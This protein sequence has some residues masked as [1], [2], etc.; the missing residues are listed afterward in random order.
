MCGLFGF[1]SYTSTPP[2]KLDTLTSALAEESAIRGT[3]ATG[4][5][6]VKNGIQI[7]KEAKSAYTTNL[8]HS[9]G[10]RSLIGHTR[11]STQGSEKK[12]YNNHPFFGKAGGVRFALAHNGILTNDTE[13][14]R[15]CSLPQTK[16][17]TDSYIAVQLL[18]ASRELTVG[19]ICKMAEAV[20]GSFC[21]SILSDRNDLYL[22]R[23]DNPLAL[24]HFPAKRMYVYASTEEILYRALVL[25]PLFDD[26]KHGEFEAIP[27]KMGTVTH[28]SSHGKLTSEDFDFTEAYTRPWWEYSLGEHEYTGILHSVAV[29]CGIDPTAVDTLLAEGFTH[30]EIEEYLYEI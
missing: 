29:S 11:H 3:D 2:K 6:F 1:S 30:E 27:L 20:R 7:H 22:V 15:R 16:I 23:G 14:R 4:I 26:L 19:S 28:I 5:A 21:F 9:E 8:H 12:N 24:L 10:I 17:E 25:S 18:E 13:L